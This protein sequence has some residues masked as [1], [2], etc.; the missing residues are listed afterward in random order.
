MALV[1]VASTA[2]TR[3]PAT[4]GTATTARTAT[5]AGSART[6][7][8]GLGASFVDVQRAPAQIFPVQGGNGF[9]SFGIVGH[10][11]EGKSARSSGVAISDHTDLID[12]A[13]R[14]KR[15]SVV[16]LPV[17]TVRE[18]ANKSF[19]MDFLFL[20][21]NARRPDFVGGFG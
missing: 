5:A 10:F 1:V 14:L 15:R 16:P 4:A 8:I 12:L 19:F 13:M 3:T 11:H 2:A 18:I 7:A 6:T 20:R 17:V 21:A 9:L